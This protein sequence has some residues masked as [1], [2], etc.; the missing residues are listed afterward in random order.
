MPIM[1][2]PHLLIGPP[3]LGKSVIVRHIC[4]ALGLPHNRLSLPDIT[5]NF[6]LTGNSSSWSGAKPGFIAE[7]LAAGPLPW[8][9]LDELDKCGHET[10]FPVQ[11]TLLS[12]LESST[13]GEFRDECLE[14][15]LD[16]RPLIFTFTAN[17][18]ESIDPALRSR[19]HIVNA[20]QPTQAEMPSI[21]K[22]VDAELR[23]EDP[24]VAMT[25]APLGPSCLDAFHPQSP[26]TIKH[27]LTAAYL[28]AL[29]RHQDQRIRIRAKDIQQVIRQQISSTRERS[30]IGFHTSPTPPI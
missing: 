13:A 22:S 5:A 29:R 26:R 30:P 27:L 17:E 4:K 3:G 19:L 9:I 8:L 23:K 15:S 10:R 18:I 6:V 14:T 7:S 28:Y 1:V 21:V 12:L 2:K 20:R 24:R 11:P 25:F 16:I